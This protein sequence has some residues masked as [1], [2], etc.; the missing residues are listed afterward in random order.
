MEPLSEPVNYGYQET[1][2]RRAPLEAN[3]I[4]FS[5]AGTPT[6]RPEP[7]LC[8]GDRDEVAQRAEPGER[9]PLELADPLAGQV[10]LVSD[11]LERPGLALEAEGQLEEPPLA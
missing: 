11:R 9:L 3:R 2:W 7:K 8:R 1:I 10:E 6:A 4:G 5:R